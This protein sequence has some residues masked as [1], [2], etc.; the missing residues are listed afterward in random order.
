MVWA[1]NE[2][3]GNKSSYD[4]L[5]RILVMKVNVEKRKRMTKREMFGCD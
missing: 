4:I 5:A 3:K 2:G 1:Y